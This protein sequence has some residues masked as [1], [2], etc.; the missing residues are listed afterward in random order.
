MIIKKNIINRNIVGIFSFLLPFTGV[1]GISGSITL[2][3]II[4]IFLFIYSIK[5]IYFIKDDYIYMLFFISLGIT[6]SI[7]YNTIDFSTFSYLI[8]F[9]L[10]FCIFYK[11]MLLY[12]NT[13]KRIILK[14]ILLSTVCLCIFIIYEFITR[15]FYPNIFIDLPR[16]G[17]NG[18]NIYDPIFLG[19]YIRARGFMEESGHASLFLEFSVPLSL[20]YLDKYSNKKF[21]SL[22]IVLV[23]ISSFFINSA[24]NI[25]FILVLSCIYIFYNILNTNIKNW[26]KMII[27]LILMGGTIKLNI[28]GIQDSII[29]LI[30][31]ANISNSVSYDSSASER[32]EI[33]NTGLNIVK[34]N[35]LIGI[36]SHNMDLYGIEMNTSLNLYIDIF[37][38]SGI[39]GFIYFIIYL[40]IKLKKIFSMKSDMKVY[41]S[42]SFIMLCIHYCIITNFWYPW[43]WIL[44]AIIDGEFIRQSQHD[45]NIKALKE[46][47]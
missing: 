34:N 14:M 10:V 4:G 3:M 33:L 38:S 11:P 29:Y 20:Y 7:R 46:S 17:S 42:L 8:S 40:L 19:K 41:L 27:I 15:N 47:K 6:T 26:I 5:K 22:F 32:M 43:L 12:Y 31:K 2:P 21:K 9:L 23:L 1:M 25:S 13:Y 24:I 37:I 16:T 30:N 35:P 39:F 45:N 28:L 18:N 36:G 44:I